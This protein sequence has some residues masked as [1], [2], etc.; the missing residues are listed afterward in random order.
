MLTPSPAC[1][2]GPIDYGLPLLLRASDCVKNWRQLS[3]RDNALLCAARG[4]FSDVLLHEGFVSSQLDMP[5][6]GGVSKGPA[7]HLWQASA[8][9]S[10]GQDVP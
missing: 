2:P 7:L 3:P 9:S 5:R 1:R 8:G 6:Q 4:T 10:L